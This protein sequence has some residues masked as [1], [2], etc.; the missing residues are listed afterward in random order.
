MS[1]IR[2][3]E[4]ARDLGV[5]TTNLLK[6]INDMG[7][8]VRSAS[9]TL[10]A[11]VEER[12]RRRFAGMRNVGDLDKREVV[13]R[14]QEAPPAP[15]WS[16]DFSNLASSDDSG[17]DA[18]LLRMLRGDGLSGRAT[19]TRRQRRRPRTDA[20]PGA[21]QPRRPTVVHPDLLVDDYERVVYHAGGFRL[22]EEVEAQAAAWQATDLPTGV[23][24]EWLSWADRTLDPAVVKKMVEAGFTAKTAF[25]ESRT[26]AGSNRTQVPY[27]LV[28]KRNM[29]P[30]YVM[31]MMRRA[32]SA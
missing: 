6:M 15:P 13:V 24:E 3:F 1:R 25:R 2:V 32:R 16:T 29:D 14:A 31:E 7:E 23:I 18:A 11:S 4:L 19:P 5:D 27:L 26:S 21:W 28:A 9:S 20:R 12:V 22:L 30:R 17:S 8:F 10:D